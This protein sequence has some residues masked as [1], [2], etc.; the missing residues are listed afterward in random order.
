MPSTLNLQN[1]INF[2][3][4]YI[5]YQPTTIGGMEPAL[6][7]AN[8]ILQTILGPPFSWRWNRSTVSVLC[9]AGQQDYVET[10]ADFGF[11]EKATVTSADGKDI[12]EIEVQNILS[13]SKDPG[14]PNYVA[15]QFDDG[16]GDITFRFQKVPEQA[17]T[18]EITYQKKATPLLCLA[19]K[20]SPVPDEMAYIVNYGFL[21]LITILV[22]DA[23]WPIFNQMFTSHLLGAQD[24]LDEMQRNIF[25]GRWLEI[26]KAAER[27]QL[28]TQQGV[29]ARQR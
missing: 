25:L 13:K 27:A 10:V 3:A 24:G 12:K 19:S 5:N 18:A 17:Y 11:I 2:T 7:A 4:P 14:R 15:A 21:A 16:N 29:A 20:W 9:V 22:N 23:R 8:I 6:S 1:T 26:T 28:K